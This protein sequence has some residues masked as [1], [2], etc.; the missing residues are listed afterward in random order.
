MATATEISAT[1]WYDDEALYAEL[2]ISAQALAKARR[3]RSLR[4][5]RRGNRTLYFGQWVL[6][7]LLGDSCPGRTTAR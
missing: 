4:F 1:G 6:A 2:G 3:E 7:W 5:T